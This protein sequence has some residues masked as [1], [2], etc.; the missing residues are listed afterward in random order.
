M[1]MYSL[2]WTQTQV[3]RHPVVQDLDQDPTNSQLSKTFS[4]AEDQRLTFWSVIELLEAL[5]HTARIQVLYAVKCN[6]KKF[7]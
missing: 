5:V 4:T 6:S 7:V 2:L 3:L 1:I